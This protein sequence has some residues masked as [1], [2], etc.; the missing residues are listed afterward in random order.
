MTVANRGVD[1]SSDDLHEQLLW[2][3]HGAQVPRGSDVLG[4]G[5]NAVLF[6]PVALFATL[7][8]RRPWLVAG[9]LVG[10]S[11]LVETAQAMVL[12]GRP[13][14]F[15]LLANSIGAIIGAALGRLVISHQ[16]PRPASVE[17]SSTP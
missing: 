4:W 10:V 11:M 2:W 13:D 17:A 16:R 9:V 15:D 6:I 3:T 14:Q 5:F 7:L 12:T 8:W 1:V